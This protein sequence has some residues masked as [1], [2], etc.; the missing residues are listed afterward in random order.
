[1][2]ISR[3]NRRN[4]LKVASA[5]IAG[6]AVAPY[7]WIPK[8][9][10]AHLDIPSSKHNHVLLFSLD[11]GCRTV[12]MF[13]AGLDMRWA[14]YGVQTGSPGTEWSVSGVFDNMP[15]QDT[16]ALGM[17]AVPSLPQIS[18]E[19]AILGTIDHTPGA[20]SGVGDH[21]TAR[22][23]IG[24]GFGEGGPGIISRIYAGHKLYTEGSNGL[25]F[26]PAVI[27]T[28]QATTPIGIPYGS[29]TPVMVPSHSE[30]VAQN[31]DDAGGQ[32]EWAR[33]LEA[34]LDGYAIKSR[35]NFDK[36][37]ISRLANGKANVEAFRNVFLD[38]ALKVETEPTGAAN[39]LTNA[40]LAAILGT[41][42]LGRD[43]ALALRFLGYGSAAVVVGHSGDGGASVGGW[44]THS[45]EMTA[46]P[47][48]ANELARVLAGL[49]Y[50]LKMMPH[51]EGGT[52][53]DHTLIGM[54]TEF[55]RDN[56]N[57]D[58]YNSGGGS[59][60]TGGPG[61]RY[62]SWFVSGGLVT[63]GGKQFGKTDAMTM[64]VLQDEPV[65]GTTNYYA[66]MLS[67]LD[68]DVEPIW[69]GIEPVNVIF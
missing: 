40:Q 68:I 58:G 6:A 51:P 27:G 16:V 29:I 34:G 36:Q 17:P 46:Y 49:N 31:G 61:S 56:T 59:D 48:A 23:W 62:Q 28:G 67:L 22:N 33:A 8:M 1:M 21:Q 2:S 37:V 44:D 41:S 66:M 63:Q 64:E 52:F 43:T 50:A 38:P 4:F 14:P 60:H 26:P 39:G 7:V 3:A 24:S 10:K 45:G 19:I 47:V 32:P 30:F 13:N 18:H 42:Q 65:F 12:P 69:P 54:F 5:A 11:G 25:V 9:S 53:W 57:A 20:S 35:G 55:G 15:Y